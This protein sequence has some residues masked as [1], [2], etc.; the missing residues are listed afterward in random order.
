MR[1]SISILEHDY[2]R[3]RTLLFPTNGNENVA[4]LR[5]GRSVAVDAWSGALEERFLCREIVEVSAAHIISATPVSVT[6]STKA[7]YEL[8][9]RVA[10]N[11]EAIGLIHSHRSDTAK[12]SPMDDTS[13]LEALSIVFNRNGGVRP[14]FSAVMTERGNIV[15]RCYTPELRDPEGSVMVRVIGERWRFFRPAEDALAPEAFDRQVRVFGNSTTAALRNLRVGIVGCGG[16]GSAVALLAGRVGVGHIA[17]FDADRVEGSNLN[18]LHFARQAD[19]DAGAL[20]VDVVGAGLAELGLGVSV[21]KFSLHVEDERC[22]D[23]LKSCD[24]IFGCTDDNRGRS[25][26]NRL[27]H[28]YLIPIIDMGVLIEPTSDGGYDTFDGRVTVVQP[29]YPCQLCRRLLNTDKMRAEVLARA[30]PAAYE[31]ERRA[32]YV[33]S[34]E[35]PSPVVATFTAEVAAMAINEL[36]QRMTGFRGDR[37]S[38]SERVR[39]FDAAKAIDLIAAGKRRPGCPLCDRRVFDGQGDVEPFLDES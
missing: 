29:G 34:L 26:L 23:A 35:D 13:E 20:K 32:G 4:L 19:A 16:T 28:F 10:K 21:R 1:S 36:L 17:L 11:D 25:L 38:V 37:G 18:R 3:L 31:R 33:P 9:K 27:A 7:V 6:Y 14:H 2:D 30:N 24:I 5:C 22:R 39:R 12:F 8:A 15:A